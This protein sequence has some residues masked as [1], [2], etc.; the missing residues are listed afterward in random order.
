MRQWTIQEFFKLAM[1]RELPELAKEDKHA[2][3]PGGMNGCEINLGAGNSPMLGCYNLDF[4]EWDAENYQIMAPNYFVRAWNGQTTPAMCADLLMPCPSESV[5]AIHAFH[6][7]EHLKDPRR[8]LR[9]IQRVLRPGGVANICVPHYSSM[10]AHY[11]LDHKS[12][13]SL[14]TWRN[15]FKSTG[16]DKDRDGWKLR[17][18]FNALM[19]VDERHFAILTQLVKEA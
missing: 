7:L 12:T 16:Y 3:H 14:E 10:L 17:V 11:D 8:M 15:T 13:W 6:F 1:K 19:A 18:H 2:T 5:N 4:P 9:E